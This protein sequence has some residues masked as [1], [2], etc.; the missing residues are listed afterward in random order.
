LL[1]AATPNTGLGVVLPVDV[2]AT[3]PV[4]SASRGSFMEVVDA[5]RV[6]DLEKRGVFDMPENLA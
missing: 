5:E 3:G 1:L 6:D 2:I 4:T